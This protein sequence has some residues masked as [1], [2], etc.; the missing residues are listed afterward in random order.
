VVDVRDD[1]DIAQIVTGGHAETFFGRVD[2]PAI[3]L[4]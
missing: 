3:L 2:N 1:R 4:C